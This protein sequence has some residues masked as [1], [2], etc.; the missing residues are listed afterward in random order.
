MQLAFY[1]RATRDLWMVAQ[2]SPI[3]PD[4][5]AYCKATG[6]SDVIVDE[7]LAALNCLH[8][9]GRAHV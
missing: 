8:E 3:L 7:P 2:C 4:G 5:E 6:A 1:F 9:I